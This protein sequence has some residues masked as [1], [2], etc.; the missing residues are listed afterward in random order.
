LRDVNLVLKCVARVIKKLFARTTEFES[1]TLGHG[2]VAAGE[3]T[4]GK[5]MSTC[6]VNECAELVEGPE[7]KGWRIGFGVS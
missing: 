2:G 7:G 6:H 4:H 5:F 1:R 3:E